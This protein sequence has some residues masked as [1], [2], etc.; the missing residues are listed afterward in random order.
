M[1]LRIVFSMALL[2]TNLT[3][4]GANDDYDPTRDLAQPR[5][6]TTAMYAVGLSNLVDYLISHSAP[7][8][9]LKTALTLLCCKE[10]SDRERNLNIHHKNNACWFEKIGWGISS[11]G[12]FITS[13]Y[14]A[15]PA[16]WLVACTLCAN[17]ESVE[18]LI[19][20]SGYTLQ[21]VGLTTVFTASVLN[22]ISITNYEKARIAN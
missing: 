3:L 8:N 2:I 6:A 9:V 18:T 15:K 4:S 17:P 13:D 19:K 10:A 5:A 12:S 14:V 1:T 11:V 16:S 20:I 22:D 7:T 21:T